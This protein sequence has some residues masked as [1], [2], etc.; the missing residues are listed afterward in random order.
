MYILVVLFCYKT[1]QMKMFLCSHFFSATFAFQL[2]LNKTQTMADFQLFRFNS[3]K[4]GDE[5]VN[6]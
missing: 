3:G 5:I 6:F 2:R 1:Q 4:W